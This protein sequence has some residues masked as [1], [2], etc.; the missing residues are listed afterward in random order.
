MVR[1]GPRQMCDSSFLGGGL[2]GALVLHLNWFQDFVNAVC[3]WAPPG[4]GNGGHL[5]PLDFDIKFFYYL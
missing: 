4:R 5:T 3:T 1:S 2:S